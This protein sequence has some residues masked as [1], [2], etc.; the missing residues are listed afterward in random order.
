MTDN[1]T[2]L[3][4]HDHVR[5]AKVITRTANG[6]EIKGFDDARTFAWRQVT[7]GGLD[8]IQMML[9]QLRGDPKSCVIRGEPMG[10][11]G[12]Q[13]IVNRRQ[14]VGSD[15]TRPDWDH[16]AVGRQWVAFDLDKV[17]QDSFRGDVPV[18]NDEQARAIV[19]QVRAEVMPPAFAKAACVYKLSSSAGLKGWD[20][21]SMHLWF[22]L[23][24]RVHDL[25]LREYCKA[26]GF[27]ISFSKCV[28]PHYTADPVFEGM[29][30]PLAGVRLGRLPGRAI[31]ETP[32]ELLDGDA[33]RA[34][35]QQRKDAARKDL[36]KAARAVMADIPTSRAATRAYAL[37][38]LAGGCQDVL[39][40]AEGT[41]HDQLIRVAY[42]LGGYCQPGFLDVSE[43]IQTLTRTVEAVFPAGRQRDELRTVAEMVEGG[44]RSPRDLSHIGR[45]KGKLSVVRPEPPEDDDDGLEIIGAT[46][47]QPAR[48][49]K[50][51]GPQF[52]GMRDDGTVPT[53]L[54]NVKALLEHYGVTLRLNVMTQETEIALP[55]DIMGQSDMRQTTKLGQIR[56]L[57]RKHRMQVGDALR[58]ELQAVEDLNAYHPVTDW[59]RS[60]PWDGVDRFEALLATIGLRDEAQAHAD[61]YRHILWAWLVAGAKYA[62]LA[63]FEEVGIKA[64]GVLVLQGPQ[65]CGKTEWVKA[66]APAAGPWVG[67]GITVDPHS[68][69]DVMK[70]TRYWITEL[71]EIDSTVRKADVGALKAFLSDQRDVYRRPYKEVTESFVRRTLFAASVNPQ[72]FLKD[73]TGNRRFWVVPVERMN[74]WGPDGILTIDMQQLWAQFAHYAGHGAEHHLPPEVER[75]QMELAEMHRQIDPVEDEI[76]ARFVVDLSQPER[77]WLTTADIYRELYPDRE[78]DKWTSADKR[79]VAAVLSQ[80]GATKARGNRGRLWSLKRRL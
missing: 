36:E 64:F 53:T 59:V 40:A 50:A 10:H 9:E 71:G 61:L 72:H 46:A 55:S 23:D 68:K 43:V 14:H 56:S 67:T 26:H 24:R 25:S 13:S 28:Q 54:G 62:T 15:G 76:H 80:M 52:E 60:K 51:K 35:D 47:V 16:H 34:R 75:R 18:P 7:V 39:S 48:K 41:R 37:R 73:T 65:G 45:A 22:W 3:R 42:N 79:A 20:R 63:P 32:A 30:D 17:A 8:D 66:L 33:W 38:A 69:D 12:M 49:A 74:V 78:L 77:Y 29:A 5:L 31:V 2:V 57:A 4:C 70:A 58:D 6:L 11:V 27:D 21:V 19:Y 44:A 1:I